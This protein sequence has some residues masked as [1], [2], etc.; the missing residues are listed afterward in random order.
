MMMAI[1]RISGLACFC[2][3]ISLQKKVEDL[4]GYPRNDAAHNDDLNNF[5]FQSCVGTVVVA[6]SFKYACQ[7]FRIQT[8]PSKRVFALAAF[9]EGALKMVPSTT[10]IAMEKE[11]TKS[12]TENYTCCLPD[13]LGCPHFN[14]MQPHGV[15]FTTAIWWCDMESNER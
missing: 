14:L 11:S 10:I 6:A 9:G 5:G 7:A 1:I 13:E 4:Q 12:S 15:D 2:N 8:S 3:C